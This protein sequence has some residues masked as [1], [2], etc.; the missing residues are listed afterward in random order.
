MSHRLFFLCLSCIALLSTSNAYAGQSEAREVARLNNCP[1]K[2][3]EVVKNYLGS[4][5]KTIY[6]ISCTLPKMTS[7][8][9]GGPDAILIGCH[10]T[11]CT[12]IRPLS[13]E[14]K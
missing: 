12:L 4:T 1:P 6:Q 2:K 3:I 8:D 14:K 10:Q 9:A 7:E 13:A 5:G 11:L